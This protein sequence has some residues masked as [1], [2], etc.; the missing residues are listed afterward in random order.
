LS[1]LRVRSSD[2]KSSTSVFIAVNLFLTVV[3]WRATF[4]FAK[5]YLLAS[6]ILAIGG[7]IAPASAGVWSYSPHQHRC[8]I[9]LEG[10][11]LVSAWQADAI[12]FSAFLTAGAA[13]ISLF[14]TASVLLSLLLARLRVREAIQD[15]DVE[16]FPISRAVLRII[17][18]PIVLSKSSYITCCVFF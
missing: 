5:W 6:A 8:M 2:S 11:Y 18:Y 1:S 14:C 16:E 4:G 15:A 12:R 3:Y 10:W 9:S 7:S 17:P 13:L